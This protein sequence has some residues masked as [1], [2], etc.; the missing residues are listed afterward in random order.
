MGSGLTFNEVLTLPAGLPAGDRQ[1]QAH[2]LK[3]SAV[4]RRVCRDLFFFYL[5]LP[6]GRQ[7]QSTE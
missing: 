3:N 6:T 4:I 5:T 2:R 1:A 7:A